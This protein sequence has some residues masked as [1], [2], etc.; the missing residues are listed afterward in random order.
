MPKVLV[1]LADGFEEMESL[2]PMNVLRRAGVEVT[3][4]A[5]KDGIHLTGRSSITI[6]ADCPFGAVEGRY[7]YDMLLLPGGP[8]ISAL[9]ADGRAAALARA[10]FLAGKRLAAICAAP[11]LLVD[12]GVLA[13]FQHYTCHSSVLPEL[14]AA[15]AVQLVTD[16][17]LTT[18]S[19][20]G[21]SLL[22]GLELVRLLCGEATAQEVARAIMLS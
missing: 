12:A 8:H 22:F 18:A 3:L 6:H 5:M 1:L 11:T 7:S 17:M 15:S 16:G 14:P 9:R 13:H 10:Y 19:G 21:A 2:C 20:A 4:A